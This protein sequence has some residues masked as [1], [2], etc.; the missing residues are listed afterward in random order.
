MNKIDNIRNKSRYPSFDQYIK[1]ILLRDELQNDHFTPQH[2][3]LC[4]PE[5]R[6][7][8]II[9]LEHSSSQLQP[10][11]NKLML[12]SSETLLGPYSGQSTDPRLQSTTLLA[13][14]WLS[15]QDQKYID[16]LYDIFKADFAMMNYSNFTH[17]DFPLPI[18]NDEEVRL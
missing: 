9:P 10:I 8:Y 16:E 13:R 12:S 7:D 15:R 4:L 3:T 11:I 5:T 18:I 1:W 14:E 6:Y 17:P 2:L